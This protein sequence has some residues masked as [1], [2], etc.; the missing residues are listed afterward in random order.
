MADFER[1]RNV[2]RMMP[3]EYAYRL[4]LSSFIASCKYFT[5]HFNFCVLKTHISNAP[6]NEI[7]A[8]E[9]CHNM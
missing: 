6:M 9:I 1:I 7:H 8:L 5:F 3:P 2:P 4:L